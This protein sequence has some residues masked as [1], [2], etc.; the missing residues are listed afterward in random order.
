MSNEEIKQE[1]NKTPDHFSQN[2]LQDILSFLKQF[3]D[4]PSISLF[5]AHHFTRAMIEDKELLK[6]LAQ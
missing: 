1:I 2:A 3:K 4:Q 6:R 5:S